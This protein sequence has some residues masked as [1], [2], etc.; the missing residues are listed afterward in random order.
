MDALDVRL[1]KLLQ[2]DG[3][4]TVSQ[5]SEI[6]RLSRPSVSERLGRLRDRGIIAGFCA[7]VPPAGVGR[8]MLL[9][10][11][12]SQLRVNHLDFEKHIRSQ[13]YILECHRVTGTV[14]YMLKA[15]V[16]GMESL[17]T[18]VDQLTPFGTI[19]SSIVLSSP[20]DFR[21][22]LPETEECGADS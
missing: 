17:Q 20:V 6:L 14:S 8:S 1:L 7:R 10:I 22:I 5:L 12:V 19:N 16:S 13:P 9:F 21:P 15:A 11:Q 4:M 2:E 3:R 18:L